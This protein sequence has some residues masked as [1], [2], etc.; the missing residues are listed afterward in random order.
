MK[1]ILLFFWEISKIVI[2]ALLIVIPIRYFIFQPFFVRGQS[3]EPNFQNG[4]YLI[5][6]EISYRLRNPERGEV[7]VFKYPLNPTQRYIK[8]IIGLPGETVKIRDGKVNVY[9]SNGVPQILDEASYL[10]EFTNTFG[11]T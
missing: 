7:V 8:R 1:S 11:D 6:D 9:D 4:D 10:P 3:M 5:V 2:V